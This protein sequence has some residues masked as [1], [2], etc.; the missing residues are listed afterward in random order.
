MGW[1]YVGFVTPN[2]EGWTLFPPTVSASLLRLGFIIPE[3]THSS[4]CRIRAYYGS[5]VGDSRILYPVRI[6]R[7]IEMPIP[8]TLPNDELGLRRIGVRRFLEGKNSLFAGDLTWAITLF[9]F[10]PDTPPVVDG[11]VYG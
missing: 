2:L 6:D 7:I 5:G 11:G 3:Q 8:A 10:I 9:E 1:N 4:Y